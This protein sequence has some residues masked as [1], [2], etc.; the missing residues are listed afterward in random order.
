MP[1]ERLS[2][3]EVSK[4]T[5]IP[6]KTLRYYSDEGIVPPSGRSQSGYR[7]YSEEDVVKL[8]LVRTLRDAG[9]DLSSIGAVLRRD[10]TLAEALRLRLA[11][12]EAHVASLRH[13]AAALRAALR[14]EPTELDIRRL[15]T[16]T[17]L[18]NEE[19][20]AV[21]ERFYEKVAE[22]IPVDKHWMRTMIEASS[23]KLPDDPTPA[24]LDAWIELADIVSDP[25]FIES[26][27]AN[28]QETWKPGFDLG[29]LRALNDRTL[30]VVTAAR[31]RGV[32]PTSAEAKA[33]IDEY[34]EGMA[35]LTSRS[36]DDPKFRAG[37]R[38]RFARQDPRASRY[39]ELIAILNGRHE[40][41][42]RVEEW[43]WVVTALLHHVDAAGNH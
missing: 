24:Q 39:W 1:K 26:I 29:G 14:S 2:I 40:M 25:K 3:G 11:A 38:E 18:S 10:M 6:V 20:K 17:R 43:K 15:C 16:V 19:R 41:S 7:L 34:L 21:I 13:I 30:E 32:E 12:V 27:R 22:G 5:G 33:I 4:R 36:A 37:V 31:E 23:P 8:D 35:R 28:A 42:T 9:L